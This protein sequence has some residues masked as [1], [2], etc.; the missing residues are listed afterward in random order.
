LLNATEPED[1]AAGHSA[2][3]VRRFTDRRTYA[4]ANGYL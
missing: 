1:I 2:A 4:D 3:P